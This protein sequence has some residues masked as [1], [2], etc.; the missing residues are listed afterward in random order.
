MK[1]PMFLSASFMAFWLLNYYVFSIYRYPERKLPIA[2]NS[3]ALL[4]MNKQLSFINADMYELELIP[5][6][7]DINGSKT[8]RKS[9]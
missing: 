9:K 1:P 2:N 6:I 7:S 5:S 3:E 4:A 8:Y